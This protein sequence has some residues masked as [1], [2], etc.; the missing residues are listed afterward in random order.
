MRTLRLRRVN[1]SVAQVSRQI[2]AG[3]TLSFTTHGLPGRLILSQI[4]AGQLMINDGVALSTAAGPLRLSDAGPVL[5]L[6]GNSPVVLE[7]IQQS[8]YWQ[9][10]NQQLSRPIAA[11]LAPIVPIENDGDL[12]DALMSCSLQVRLGEESVYSVLSASARTLLNLLSRGRWLPHQRDLPDDWQVTH[13]VLLGQVSL[14]L[15]QLTSLRPGDVLLP[16]LCH[17][18]T[19]GNGHLQIAGDR[20]RVGTEKKNDRLVVRLGSGEHLDD[21]Q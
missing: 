13:P 7:G 8:W 14:T 2:G 17:F 4:D 20:W 9:Y 15:E 10:V 5:S 12:A 18:D 21:G 11:L 16:S 1:R 19:D 3:V 6:L